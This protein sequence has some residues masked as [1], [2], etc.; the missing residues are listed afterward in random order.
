MILESSVPETDVL[1]IAPL[2]NMYP[3][4]DLHSDPMF[5]I[6][7][8]YLLDEQGIVLVLQLGLGPKSLGPKPSVLPLHQ[9][10]I[11]APTG[12]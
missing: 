12:N 5:R 8:S 7:V 1:P 6:H 9:S 11:S 2:R 10:R 3:A 4:R